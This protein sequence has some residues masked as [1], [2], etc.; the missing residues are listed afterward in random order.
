M[1]LT[2]M[3]CTDTV[4]SHHDHSSE[5]ASH[6]QDE[7][8]PETCPPFCVCSCCGTITL[9]TFSIQQVLI[10]EQMVYHHFRHR[11]PEPRNIALPVWQPPKV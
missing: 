9:S 1:L 3:P 4:V 11:T 8:E 10:Q 6:E 2:V 7:N 5:I